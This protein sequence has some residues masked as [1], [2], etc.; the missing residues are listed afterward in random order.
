[1]KRFLAAA[2]LATLPLTAAAFD[3]GD[4]Q[5]VEA[6]ADSFENAF[7]AGNFTEILSAMP[8]KLTD[9]MAKQ[10]GIKSSELA[11]AMGVQM[12]A[13]AAGVKIEKMSMNTRRMITGTTGAG[14]DYAFIPTTTTATAE[15]QGRKT[16]KTHTLALEDGGTW[17]MLRIDQAQQYELVKS[18]YPDFAAVP[19]P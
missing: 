10:M 17:Y 2:L 9:Y 19:L 16:S 1:M 13:L 7:L 11:P 4:R 12:Q 3:D 5:R 14:T 18:V 6:R 8:P 15:G